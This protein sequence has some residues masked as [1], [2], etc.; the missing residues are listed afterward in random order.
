MR[1]T[2]CTGRSLC[3]RN[4][5]R[6]RIGTRSKG[7]GTRLLVAPTWNLCKEL[8]SHTARCTARSQYR[9]TNLRGIRQCPSGSPRLP[10]HARRCTDSPVSSSR[11]EDSCQSQSRTN[12]NTR[13]T[14]LRWRMSRE[15]SYLHD[16]WSQEKFLGSSRFYWTQTHAA[17]TKSP[18]NRYSLHCAPHSDWCQRRLCQQHSRPPR[19]R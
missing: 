19:S 11:G 1:L 17:R 4:R 2:R 8:H 3:L 16:Q 13:E 6:S 5:S 15:A 7:F 18:P 14:V 9:E 12:H 10:I